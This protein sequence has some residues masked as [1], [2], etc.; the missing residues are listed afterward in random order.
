MGSRGR[1]EIQG[2]RVGCARRETSS[3]APT[4]FLLRAATWYV[5]LPAICTRLVAGDVDVAAGRDGPVDRPDM[6]TATGP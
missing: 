4:P 5:G 6:A 2:H 1:D 3:R